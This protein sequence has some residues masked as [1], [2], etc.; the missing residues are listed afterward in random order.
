ML[1]AFLKYNTIPIQP[2]NNNIFVA[3]T[4][5]CPFASVG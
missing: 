4:Y 5:N 2:T 3:G 1:D